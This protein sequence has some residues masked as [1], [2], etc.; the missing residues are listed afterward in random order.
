MPAAPEIVSVTA[1]AA[2]IR[3]LPEGV[4]YPGAVAGGE[5]AVVDL[6]HAYDTG[7]GVDRHSPSPIRI[8]SM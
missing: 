8:T 3:V 2:V 4:R 7:S 6:I 5:L 1:S